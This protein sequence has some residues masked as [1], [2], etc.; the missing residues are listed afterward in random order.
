M[1]E[2]RKLEQEEQEEL[3]FVAV[4]DDASAEM[5][6]QRIKEADEQ[7]ERMESWYCHQLENAKEIRDRTVQWAET[8]LR[9]YFDM[10]PTKNAKTQKSYE[11]PSGKLVLKAQQPEFS[12][13]DE[14]LVPWL[15]E[16]GL[17]DFVKVKESANWAELKK[18]VMVLEDTVTDADGEII[19]GITVTPREPKFSVTVK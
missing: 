18:R 17:N 13:Q 12:V 5:L 11:L 8:C 10:V 14:V 3:Q 9:G 1:S 15:K 6:L 16:R 2:A 7:Y 19:P 4:L